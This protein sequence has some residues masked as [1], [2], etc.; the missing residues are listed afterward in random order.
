[1]KRQCMTLL[2]VSIV[3]ALSFSKAVAQYDWSNDPNNPRLADG[4][5]VLEPSVLYD[6]TQEKYDLWYVDLSNIKRAVS[7]DG[8]NWTP[9]AVS[10][11]LTNL[12]ST[13]VCAGAEVIKTDSGYFMYAGCQ[14]Q[15]GSWYLALGSSVDGNVWTKH[16]SSP[17]LTRGA[18]GSWDGL[19]VTGPHVVTKD[20]IYYMFYTG[21][22]AAGNQVGLATSTDGVHWEKYGGNPVIGDD[23]MGQA[24][25]TVGPA[26]VEAVDGLFYMVLSVKNNANETTYNLATSADGISWSFYDGNPILGAGTPGTWNSSSIGGGTLR[27][28]SGTYRFWYCGTDASQIWRMGLATS[29]SGTPPE[30]FWHQTGGP[31]SSQDVRILASSSQGH[32]FAGT[33]TA[34][35]VYKTTNNGDT[36]T[37]CGPIPNTNPVLGLTI[38]RHDHLFASVYL[39]GIARS[40]DNGAT[41]E[42][43]NNGLTNFSARW[44]IMDRQGNIWVATEGGLFRTSDDGENWTKMHPAMCFNVWLD[45]AGAVITQEGDGTG[46]DS[47]GNTSNYVYRST[48][49]GASWTTTHI[50][51]KSFAGIHADGSYFA[52]TYSHSTI[53][54]STDGGATWTDLHCPVSWDGYTAHMAFLPQGDIFFTKN[55]DGAGVIRSTDNGTTWEVKND[56]L[57]T[58]RVTYLF[59]HPNGYLFLA[60]GLAG[61]FRSSQ[62]YA[63]PQNIS[64]SLP[65]AA[66]AAGSTLEIPVNITSVS[67]WRVLAYEFTLSFNSPDSILSIDATPITA[68]TLSGQESW[69][70]QVNATMPNQVTVG[71]YGALPLAGEGELL[72]LKVTTFPG[73]RAGQVSNLTLTHLLFNAGTPVPIAQNG[74]LTIHDRV[75][76][77]ADENGLVQAYDA[78][79]TLREAIGPMTAPPAP[80]TAIGLLNADVTMNG[81]V[82]AYDAALILRHVLGLAMPESTSTCFGPAGGP[83]TSPSLALTG[84][85]LGVHLGV[86]QTEVQVGLANVPEGMEVLSCS[87]ELTT[88]ALGSDSVDLALPQLGG[89]YLAS[90]NR[91]GIGHYKV[92]IINP[93]GI[94]LDSIPFTLTA[95]HAS[96]LNQIVFSQILL[97]DAPNALITMSNIVTTIEAPAAPA[98]HSYDL[99]GAYPN[100]FNPSTR[101]V[102]E[103]PESGVV[104]L[105]IYNAQGSRI[106]VLNDTELGSGQHEISWDGTNSLGRAVATGHYFCVMRAGAYRKTIRLLLLR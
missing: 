61:V 99:V 79:L 100:P 53:F 10:Q 26:G 90:V 89:A 83:A 48:N 94:P 62:P 16:P 84:R 87:F 80:L 43:K 88:S 8:S 82:Q 18:P 1:M 31:L 19:A 13:G 3:L 93:Y 69:S 70:V 65:E 25:T 36:W 5:L 63:P 14:N 92:G 68:G 9:T 39:R 58:L 45:S 11:S 15:D 98:P 51:G 27:Y 34:G 102:F 21:N 30:T 91:L 23:A 67:G 60:T 66:A 86:E 38:D 35:E 106:K 32:L 104:H 105:E 29:T 76:G 50:I 40:T 41:W 22:G 24:T 42:M 7:D 64:V 77:D 54:R 4:A 55:G 74:R 17:A 71:G 33:W 78:A 12:F 95:T 85:V 81:K 44:S 46:F 103:M 73:V 75:C 49:G 57:T 52:N 96:S 20:S 47:S 101:I 56:G 37:I 2:P 97:N 59:P 6:A 28:I 72:R